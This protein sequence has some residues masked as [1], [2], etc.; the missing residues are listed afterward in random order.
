[1]KI[2]NLPSIVFDMSYN[3][4]GDEGANEIARNIDSN[5]D[6]LI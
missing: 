5:D 4:I 3:D 1:M 2:G 6:G